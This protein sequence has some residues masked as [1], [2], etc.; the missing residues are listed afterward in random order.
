MDSEFN[1]LQNQLKEL[2]TKF[3]EI[4][5]AYTKLQRR[6]KQIDTLYS[7]TSSLG[8]IHD[9]EELLKFTKNTFQNLIEIDQ[10]AF[11]LLD[12]ESHHLS[13]KSSFGLPEEWCKTNNFF[14]EGSLFKKAIQSQ[15][16]IYI[17]NTLELDSPV[18]LPPAKDPHPGSFL[19][20]PLICEKNKVL[21]VLNLYRQGIRSFN[22]EEIEIITEITEQF[23]FSLNKILLYEHTKELS[24]TDELTGF[25]NRRY[26]NQRYER[27]IQRAKRYNRSLSLIMLDID[28]F[29]VYNDLN[30]HIMGDDVLK[31]V[32]HTLDNILRK[33]DFFARF[34]G[35]EFIIMLPEISKEQ[36]CKVAN[37][38]R[39]KI[40]KTD[41]ANE[42][43]QPNKQITISL[44]L[45]VYPDD[46]M[47]PKEL[48]QYAD[49]ALYTAKSLGR[50]CVA[51]H[52]M[53]LPKSAKTA[54][55]NNSANI[56]DHAL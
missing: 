17:Q 5:E 49:Q 34:G 45:A 13:I 23:A 37:K 38:L 50:N 22:P 14:Q 28:H 42:E 40:E 18:T 24:I 27:E 9:L 26:F 25:F 2:Q 21:G 10:Y 35:E 31:K 41:F 56:V 19:C 54:F 55:K 32:A 6:F 15:K 36:A 47:V 12:A 48:I 30:G 33:T 43:M 46:S 4:E 16:S 29:K 3:V 39:Q 11:M 51:W 52:G 44:G 53:K 8:V 20:F 1:K 7:I